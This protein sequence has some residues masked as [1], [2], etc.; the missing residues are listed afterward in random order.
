MKIRFLI[1]W[2]T[3]VCIVLFLDLTGSYFSLF[4]YPELGFDKIL[5]FLAGIACGI[6]GAVLVSC[7]ESR[8]ERFTPWVRN[9]WTWLFP[10]LIAIVIGIGWELLQIY[11]P[12]LRDASDYNMQDGIG[13]VIWDA[14]GG[15]I[16]GWHY[17]KPSQK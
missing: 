9:A 4:S 14:I 1:P 10:I 13:D 17:Q 11:W 12:W 16:A 7:L 6:A 5:H 15:A 2:L 8:T 3:V